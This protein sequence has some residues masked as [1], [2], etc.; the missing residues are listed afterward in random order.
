[1]PI[2]VPN[3]IS[4][5]LNQ[6]GHRI[7]QPL[8]ELKIEG[9]LSKEPLSFAEREKGE[10]RQ[11]NI[12]ESWGGLFDCAWFKLTGSVPEHKHDLV[13][14][15]DVGGEGL[16]FDKLGNPIRGITNKMSSYGIPPDK[17]GKW[18]VEID[19]Q[20][21]EEF[22]IW[23]DAGCNDLFGYVQNGG[24]I[25]DAYL[26]SCNSALKG[27]YY[28]LEVLVDWIKGDEGFVSHQPKGAQA[29]QKLVL[30][31][32]EERFERFIQLMERV[33]QTLVDYS[34][35]E[36]ERCRAILSEIYDAPST[37]GSVDIT[38]TGHAH[39]DLAW[40]WPL[41][42]G[43]RKAMR[44]FTTAVANLDKY[45]DYLF[46][47]SQYQLFEWVKEEQPQLF[48]RIKSHVEQGR[49]ELQGCF[50]VESDLNLVSGE[51]LI[52]QIMY[53]RQFTEQHFGQSVNY[54]WEPDVFGFTAALPQILSKSG[55]DYI[56]SQKLS[57]NKIN[58]FPHHLFRWQGLD[59][60]EVI[61]HN[62]PEDT[63][64]SRAR[65][66]SSLKLEANY[67]EKHICPEALMVY[68]VGDGGGGPAEEHIER[69]QRIQNLDGLPQAKNG[70]VDAFFE[71]VEK[72]REQLPVMNGELYF[73]L[74][75]GC[76]TT[77]SRTKQGNRDMEY[78][79]G[80]LEAMMAIT[81]DNSDKAELD[82]LWKETLTLQ[83]HDILPGSSIVRVYQEAE[84]DY[85][86]LVARVKQLIST[87]T[88]KF[89]QG[90]DTSAY[91]RPY[92]LYNLSP[93]AREQWLKLEN[94]WHLASVPAYS[95]K[96]I[97]ATPSEF[98]S[99]SASPFFLE[100]SQVRVEFNAQGHIVSLF[101][102]VLNFE[103]VSE[104]RANL[105]TAY[106]E[107]AT[108]YAA[109]DFADGYRDGESSVLELVESSSFV[110]GPVATVKQVYR[111][112]NSTLIQEICLVEGSARLDFNT[113]IDWQDQDVSLKANFPVTI[114][115]ED[116]QCNIQF[117]VIDRPTHSKDS[118]AMAKDEIPAHRWVD[119]TDGEQGIA[120]MA[121]AKYGYRVKDQA[122]EI[123]L[124]RS[125]KKP[126]SEFAHPEESDFTSQNF[127][128][129][130]EHS[131]SYSIF[132]HIGD[133]RKGAVV[134]QGY[135]LRE[136]EARSI[137]VQ[138]GSFESNASVLS[139]DN[140]A[141]VMETLKPAEDGNGVIVRLFET[142]GD[143]AKAPVDVSHFGQIVSEV[144]MM[145]EAIA[146]L[147]AVNGKLQLEFTPFE[148]KTIRIN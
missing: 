141:V 79:L 12:G 5:L 53:G 31:S 17:P 106:K 126:G 118:F 94:N 63:Y 14:M 117:G 23:V 42:E 102:K 34:L 13:L 25:T 60:S 75:Q 51:S 50:W 1:M 85:T 134:E 43:K 6:V 64:D 100:N 138:Q 8:T 57:Q 10:H 54:L 83:F 3:N 36:I 11:F 139:C 130:G 124:L 28:D 65:A 4:G 113:H 41:R 18:V 135:A 68:G 121:D 143:N 7:Y 66:T 110:D 78:L 55:V 120:I 142:Y 108:L 62:F 74:H 69:F 104:P 87:L 49:F 15:V 129:I 82:S 112:M 2:S 19:H 133:Y 92:M 136:L 46:G 30:A 47:A 148:V 97:E 9:W 99:P 105:L 137:S 39:L 38:A 123:C 103:F 52:R 145:E 21:G 96:V 81:E 70:R 93:Y 72:H 122:L 33:E 116:A 40:M 109:W 84:A 131:F 26:G 44:T 128:D 95:Y 58:P 147:N 56:A 24:I 45:S 76:F 91:S 20:A 114:Q 111:Y 146:P 61:M 90:L 89:E 107:R 119:V 22:E 27:L 73:E 140:S 71:R 67:K 101:N 59:G 144:N 37:P 16:V 80:Q 127:G 29:N 115:A 32:N 88:S 35:G 98:I 48:E 132:T 77:E 125:Q 86:R